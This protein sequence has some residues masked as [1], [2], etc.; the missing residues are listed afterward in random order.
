MPARRN[1]VY[2]VRTF[3]SKGRNGVQVLP[4]TICFDRRLAVEIAKADVPHAHGVALFEIDLAK[5]NGASAPFKVYGKIP[6][7]FRRAPHSKV[8]AAAPD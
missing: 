2:V 5:P 4:P 3:V 7:A 6:G 8:I 1:L